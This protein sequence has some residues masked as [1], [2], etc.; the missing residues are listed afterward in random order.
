MSYPSL[1]HPAIPKSAV[2]RAPAPAAGHCWPVLHR[3]HSNTVLSQSL[4]GLWVLGC[5]RFVWA[6]WASLAGMG[7]DSK[8]VLAPPPP[9]S[10]WGFSFAFGCGVSFLSSR[11]NAVLY[12][13][14]HCVI[15]RASLI[16][17]LVKNLPAMQETLVQ[18][19]GQKDPLEKV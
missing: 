12:N 6:L 16:A 3:R 10:C 13:H 8:H 7:F 17:Q 15:V 14:F 11:S 1:L 19:L 18:F 4:W 5:T 9:P 2:L